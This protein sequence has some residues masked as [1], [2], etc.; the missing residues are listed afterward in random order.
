VADGRRTNIGVA[1]ASMRKTRT[2]PVAG[3]SS[4]VSMRMVVVLPA[5][6]GPSRPYISPGT[7]F[8]SMWST[9]GCVVGQCFGAVPSEIPIMQ[10]G[11]FARLPAGSPGQTREPAAPGKGFDL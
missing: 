8:R 2:V 9:A 10:A 1:T 11:A 6:F 3:L 4:L 7:I 5:S